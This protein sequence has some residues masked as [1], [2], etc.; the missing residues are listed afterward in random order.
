MWLI[1]QVARRTKKPGSRGY[2]LIGCVAL[3]AIMLAGTSWSARSSEH[4]RRAADRQQ[5]RTLLV[6]FQTNQLRT[7]SLQMVRGERGFL[8][9]GNEN[10]LAPFHQGQ[11]EAIASLEELDEL[12][13]GNPA[14]TARVAD[15]QAAYR[16]LDLVLSRMITQRR[17]GLQEL[18]LASVARGDGRLAIDSILEG[19]SSLERS[20]RE[21]LANQT[22][23]AAARATRNENYQYLLTFVGL[24]LLI[25]AGAATLSVR[26][27][28]HAEAQAKREL[29]RVAMTDE[30]TGLANR[31]S[32][33]EALDRSI[34]RAKAD[35]GRK[36]C[37]AIFDIDHFKQ[38]N[39]RFGHPAGDDV[40]REVAGRATSSLRKRDLVG[41]IGGEEFAVILPRAD[42]KEAEGVCERLRTQIAGKPVRYENCI[43]P[44]TASIGIAELRPDDTVGTLMAR[45]DAALYEAKDNGRN[46][47]RLAA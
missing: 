30:M 19:L 5:D 27:A 34:S 35:P 24:A 13:S 41:R 32:L 6:L 38:V 26:R 21:L 4:E 11:R 36:L 46:R 45:A 25:L 42:L 22:S 33:L 15:L 17:H 8:L 37:L 39:D 10:F 7:A 28:V 40:L 12:T 23:L 47:V 1:K 16:R 3:L 20:E 14:Q 29:Q 9:T 2:F 43:I 44:F 31:R 18:A